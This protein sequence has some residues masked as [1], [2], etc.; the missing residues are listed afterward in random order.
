VDPGFNPR[1]TIAF[2]LTLPPSIIN[3][4]PD[5]IRAYFRELNSKLAAIPGVQAVS[6]TS[7]AMP[8]EFDDEQMFW[9]EGQPRPANDNE[10]NQAINYNVEEDYLK[11]MQTLL[12]KGRFFTR[13]DNEHSPMVV[14]VDEVFAG[15]Y[16]SGQEALGKRIHLKWSNQ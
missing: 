15:K 13:Q 10:M 8:L 16:F 11:V 9:I 7:G 3:G 2:G 6:Q 5:E 14:V 1:N 4:S 12:R